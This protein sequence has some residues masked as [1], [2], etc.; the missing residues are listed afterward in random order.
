MAPPEAG[1]EID[2][3]PLKPNEMEK[4]ISGGK[5]VTSGE[6]K[7]TYQHPNWYA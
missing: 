1:N 7:E 6:E 5:A 3:L 4:M 2:E